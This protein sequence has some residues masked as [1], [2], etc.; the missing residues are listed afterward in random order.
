MKTMYQIGKYKVHPVHGRQIME[1]IA[2][3]HDPNRAVSLVN[4]LKAKHAVEINGDHVDD[5]LIHYFIDVVQV[6]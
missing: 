5:H 6:I 4:A 3:T 1:T 2:V